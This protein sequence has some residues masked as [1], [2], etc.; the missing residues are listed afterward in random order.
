MDVLDEIRDEVNKE[1]FYNFLQ[2]YG[3]HVAILVLAT[4]ICFII[5]FW[6]DKHK[7]NVLLEEASEYGDAIGS[8]DKDKISRLEKLK[9]GKTV[10]SDL[11]KLQL[12]AYYATNKDFNRSIHNYELLIDS[13]STDKIYRDYAELMVIKMKISSG[14]INS[15]EGI[16]MY[17]SFYKNA[18]YF[19]N[20]AVLGQSI[21]LMNKGEKGKVSS[22]LNE[23]LTDN[24]SPNLLMYLARMI[25]KRVQS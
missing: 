1:R 2:N 18:E 6:W 8:H 11:A 13:K 15:E 3:K 23:I 12:G 24:E 7:N 10:Y 21:L 19:N 5:Y 25:E 9:V 20:I 14:K 4:F 17:E 22:K 16:E